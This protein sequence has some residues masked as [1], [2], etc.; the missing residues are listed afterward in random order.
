MK[1]NKPFVTTNPHDFKLR[2]V[3][4]VDA[5]SKMVA[6]F[7]NSNWLPR[8][9][10]ALILPTDEADESNSCR[11]WGKFKVFDLVYDF[12]HQIVRVLCRPI[13]SSTSLDVRSLISKIEEPLDRWEVWEK[14]FAASEATRKSEALERQTRLECELSHINEEDV[15]GEL[16]KLKAKILEIARDEQGDRS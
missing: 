6:E 4:S 3:W 7:S 14:A 1:S 9:G 10:E 11:S 13:K 15:D 16:E 12:Q 2:I 5:S 8:I